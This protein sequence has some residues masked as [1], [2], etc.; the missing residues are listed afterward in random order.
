MPSPVCQRIPSTSGTKA[1]IS[2]LERKIAAGFTTRIA[3]S[4]VADPRYELNKP[5]TLMGMKW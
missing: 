5:A 3:Q 2:S 4:E 1:L